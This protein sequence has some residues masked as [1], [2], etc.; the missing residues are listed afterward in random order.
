MNKNI[1]NI[2]S[3]VFKSVGLAMGIAVLVLSILKAIEVSTAIILLSIGV[4]CLGL[5]LL[6]NVKK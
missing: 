4:S 6:E 3:T 2:L 5:S 1:N